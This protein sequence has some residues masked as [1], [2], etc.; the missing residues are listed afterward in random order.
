MESRPRI[1]LSSGLSIIYFQ[2]KEFVADPLRHSPKF[3]LEKAKKMK[4]NE[5][6]KVEKMKKTK[7]I[8]KT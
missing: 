6:M 5:K 7:K 4:K 1:Q 8:K 3:V 2:S